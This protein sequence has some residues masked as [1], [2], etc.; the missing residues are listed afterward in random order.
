M[1]SSGIEWVIVRPPNLNHSPAKGGYV[2][3]PRAR[4]SPATALSH[5]DCAEAFDQIRFGAFDVADNNGLHANSS[6]A[7]GNSR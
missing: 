6:K 1:T 4:I 3:G 5:A 2:A 7:I